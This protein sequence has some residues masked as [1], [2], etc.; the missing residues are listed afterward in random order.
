MDLSV[1]K[2]NVIASL[3]I[4]VG[5]EIELTSGTLSLLGIVSK[6]CRL[7]AGQHVGTKSV[8]FAKPKELRVDLDQINTASNYVNGVPS[9]LLTI[10]PVSDKFGRA[11]H[12]SYAR[13][14]IN[15]CITWFFVQNCR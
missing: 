12:L 5:T 13:P 7:P 4:P 3:E 11:L 10:I 1:N 6:H 8:D 14:A 9:S 15:G 2:N